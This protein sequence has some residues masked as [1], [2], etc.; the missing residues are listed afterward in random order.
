MATEKKKTEVR[1]ILTDE[2]L[3]R[4]VSI[5]MQHLEKH[6]RYLSLPRAINKLI[7]LAIIQ[8]TRTK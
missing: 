6:K 2:A 3:E 4:V 5:Q 7:L 1:V 8:D